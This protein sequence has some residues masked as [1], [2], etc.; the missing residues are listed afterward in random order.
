MATAKTDQESDLE[1]LL[2]CSICLTTFD[3]PR[4]LHCLHSFCK[5]CLEKF[6]ADKSDD[7]LRCPVCRCKFT[8]NERGVAGMTR[9]HFICNM[10]D[11]V[12]VQQQRKCIPCSHC[13]ES[14]VGRCVTCELFMCEKCFKP[15]NDWVGNRDHV[16]LSMEELTRPENY[17][18][19]KERSKCSQHPK[20]KFKYY[21][22][23]CDEL[24]CRHCMD[25]THEKQH[26]LLPLEEA[27]ESKREDL[28]KKCEVLETAVSK[29]NRE[30]EE[31]R[32]T[33]ESLNLKFNDLEETINKTNKTL[34]AK[35]RERMKKK[36]TSM[37]ADARKSYDDKRRY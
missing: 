16:V 7:D 12:L 36:T 17:S 11:V 30:K 8:L 35:V 34:L 10:V 14:A 2:E 24:I 21:C 19:I 20:K 6:V 1:R 5:Q 13:Q 18:K 22:E 4:T 37:I 23:T 29:G 32:S 15:H 25:F 26:K 27:A 28:K 3:E 31:L 9:N 33:H